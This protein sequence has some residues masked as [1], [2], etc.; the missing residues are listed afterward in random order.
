RLEREL[1]RQAGANADA[2][3]RRFRKKFPL[4]LAQEQA[5][6]DVDRATRRYVSLMEGRVA[7]GIDVLAAVQAAG[8]SAVAAGIDGI[9]ADPGPVVRALD[10]L[11]DWHSQLFTQPPGINPAW[12]PDRL[13]YSFRAR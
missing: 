11:R 9:G 4:R 13:A 3:I 5:R 12:M 10:V 7:D 1:R 2:A 6:G 8:A